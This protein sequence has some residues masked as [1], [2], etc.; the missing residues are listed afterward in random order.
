MT[1]LLTLGP[2]AVAVCVG[3]ATPAVAQQQ[4]SRPQPITQLAAVAQ[5]DLHGV[6]LDDRGEP[7][8]GAVVSALG[9]TTA[10]AVSD[11]EGRFAFRNLAPGPYLVRAHLQG[12]VPERGRIIQVNA[13]IRNASTIS[14]ARRDRR[15][16]PQVLAAGVG[17]TGTQPSPPAEAG[18]HDHGEVAWR[19][20][21]P[22]AQRAQGRRTR[23][24]R[25]WGRTIRC[26]ATRSRA[27]GAPSARRPGSRRACSPT[28][29][30]SGQINLLT[31]TSFDRPQ[32]LF[33]TDGLAAARRGVS[34]ARGPNRRRRVGDARG[35]DAGRSRVVD[36]RG[37]VRAACRR[38]APSTKPGCRTACSA[39]L[40]GTPMRWRR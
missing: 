14:L 17:T 16:E 33:T 20:A 4:L 21:P 32:D 9:S 13:G 35:D 5:T 28:C 6:V 27:S 8:A 1:R 10:F 40:A 30:L 26:S 36:P 3:V 29:R 24:D 7:L 37:L 2:V 19:L 22:E 12:Y 23:P 18:T 25:R 11:R 34:V 39:I 15:D 31:S 38:R